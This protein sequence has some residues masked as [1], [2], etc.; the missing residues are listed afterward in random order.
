[1][2]HH[3][4]RSNASSTSHG[5]F[6]IQQLS[7]HFLWCILISNCPSMRTRSRAK[8][9][10]GCQVI[11]L[12]DHAIHLKFSV[13]AVV[14]PILDLVLDFL[15]RSHALGVMRN[16]QAPS[17]NRGIGIVLALRSKPIAGTNAVCD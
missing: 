15:G 12:D 9:A 3:R 7:G 2:A 16:R 17:S 1:R 4:M 14:R 10:L 5:D 8:A 6:N 13:M 11:D